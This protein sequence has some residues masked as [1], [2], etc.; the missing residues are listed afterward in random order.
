MAKAKAKMPQNAKAT[1]K[2]PTKSKRKR[3]V[4]AE[5]QGIDPKAIH[6]LLGIHGPYDMPKEPPGWPDWTTFWD[7]GL[8]I[9]E[10]RKKYW[11]L[12]AY[13]D[14]Y[15]SQHFA[16]Q[17]ASWQWKQ[18]RFPILPGET[19][20]TQAAKLRT[21]DEVATAREVIAHVAVHFLR[22]GERLEFGRVR[23]RD[24]LPSGR[25]VIVS[26]G[27]FG[28]DIGSCSDAYVS[29]FIGLA[30]VFLHQE[31]RRK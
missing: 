21:G 13:T 28:F 23:C 2:G 26:F 25:R 10:L 17:T 27:R 1:A 30:A 16:K 8:S 9:L 3:L 18:L 5:P 22:T 31:K 7:P 11:D 19:F 6:A 12:F 29:P 14:W 4:A 20:E 15:E 24:L